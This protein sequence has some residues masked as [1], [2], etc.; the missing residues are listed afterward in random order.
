M[1]KFPE[2]FKKMLW[3]ILVCFTYFFEN[4]KFTHD[5]VDSIETHICNYMKI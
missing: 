4:Q 3:I 2:K 1:K 5:C